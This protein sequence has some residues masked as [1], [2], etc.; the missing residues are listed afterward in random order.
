MD[1]VV[2]GFVV[3]LEGALHKREAAIIMEAKSRME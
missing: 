2:S 3:G 1:R